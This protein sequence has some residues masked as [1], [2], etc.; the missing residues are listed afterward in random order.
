[1]SQKAPF[2]QITKTQ[3]MHTAYMELWD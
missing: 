3:L 1:M 2:K